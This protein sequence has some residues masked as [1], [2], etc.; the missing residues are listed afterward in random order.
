MVQGHYSLN[1]EYD[2]TMRCHD[3]HY[4]GTIHCCSFHCVGTFLHKCYFAIHVCGFFKLLQLNTPYLLP[5]L[6]IHIMYLVLSSFCYISASKV[7]FCSQHRFLSFPS[8]KHEN[9]DSSVKDEKP[10]LPV[11]SKHRLAQDTLVMYTSNCHFA[12]DKSCLARSAWHPAT[13]TNWLII[14]CSLKLSIFAMDISIYKKNTSFQVICL[15]F[16]L[17][18]TIPALSRHTERRVIG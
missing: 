16:C 3:Y 1:F 4:I 5:G 11:A 10:R 9:W 14:T 17:Q 8:R 12:A 15:L 7:S 18:T 2:V 6:D 13:N